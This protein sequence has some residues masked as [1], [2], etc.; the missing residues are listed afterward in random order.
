MLLKKFILKNERGEVL[1]EVT[2]KKGMNII[3]GENTKNKN[4]STNS[5]G[6]TTLIRCIDFCLDGKVDAI[7]KDPEFKTVNT[8]VADFLTQSKPTFTLVLSRS[9][10]SK[11]ELVIE[12]KLDLAAKKGKVRNFINGELYSAG[13]FT[14]ELK[15]RI[16][17]FDDDKPTF[18]QLIGKFMRNADHQISRILRF[19]GTFCSDAEYEK[20][21]LFLLGFDSSKVLTQKSETELQIGKIERILNALRTRYSRNALE[22]KLHILNSEI[23]SLQD[24][25]DSFQISEKYEEESKQLENSQLKLSE[26]DSYLADL[27]LKNHINRDRIEK[28]QGDQIA[29][30]SDSLKYLY[31]EAGYYSDNLAKT[32]D[33]LVVFHNTMVKNE[34]LYLGKALTDNA[35]KIEELEDQRVKEVERYNTLLAFLGRTGSLAEYTK[36]NEQISSKAEEIGSDA[37]LLNEL[38]FHEEQLTDLMKDQVKLNKIMQ[39]KIK[40]V[41][42]NLTVFNG[43][44]SSYT[45]QLD[46]EKY[47]LAYETTNEDVYKFKVAHLH[48]NSGSGHKQAVVAAFDL[49]Y[50][51][52]CN[53]LKI[54]RPLFATM[55]KV[56]IIDIKKLETLFNI[57][58][59]QNGQFIAPFIGDKLDGIYSEIEKDIILTLSKDDRF[60]RIE[61]GKS[62]PSRMAA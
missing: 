60:F 43:Y 46:G 48:G 41:D 24:K 18:R 30:N 2:F 15:K 25:R 53:H 57:A 4:E 29:L 54:N 14:D 36:L 13:E 27:N 7:Y 51:A 32:F 45:E 9:F 8:E 44:F 34:I 28:L 62:K 20:I 17:S 3:L 39:E 58:D 5:L 50:M 19:N 12:R 23:K 42:E 55:D 56:E 22:Q 49:A 47:L 1:R 16:F 10:A 35:I 52:F 21:H 31:D 37:A 26:I 38:T 40:I 33:E 6:K 59:Q 11:T 61:Q